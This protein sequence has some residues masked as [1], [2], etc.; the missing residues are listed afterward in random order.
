MPNLPEKVSGKQ[1]PPVAVTP[2]KNTGADDIAVGDCVIVD[3]AYTVIGAGVKRSGGASKVG[4]GVAT[5]A[6][7]KGVVAADGDTGL[8]ATGGVVDA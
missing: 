1:T 6:A 4:I 5:T 8:V 3:T 2:F 7:A